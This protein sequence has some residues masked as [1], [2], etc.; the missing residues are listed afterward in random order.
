MTYRS[1]N[2]VKT[3]TRVIADNPTLPYAA[4]GTDKPQL[5]RIDTANAF[6][7]EEKKMF[8]K[9]AFEKTSIPNSFSA[10]FFFYKYLEIT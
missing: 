2:K 6:K 5:T 7:A 1:L 4:T 9:K 3:L 8:P 10:N